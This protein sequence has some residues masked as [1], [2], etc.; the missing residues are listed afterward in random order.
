MPHSQHD[1]G[2]FLRFLAEHCPGL[3]FA[4]EM[5]WEA[6][7]FRGDELPTIHIADASTSVILYLNVHLP[8]FVHGHDALTVQQ[9]LHGWENQAHVQTLTDA[10]LT[11]AVL[12]GR[13][14]MV[15]GQINKFHGIIVPNENLEVPVY[16]EAEFTTKRYVLNSFIAH[17][18]DTSSSGHYYA[19]LRYDG[20][21]YRA[22][23]NSSA[24]LMNSVQ[25]KQSCRQSYLFFY[26]SS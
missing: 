5:T 25:F 7:S 13:F 12:A 16:T 11:L 18:G 10:P 9:L 23:D 2:D 1:V 21:Y 14:Q 20:A 8:N 6:R 24:K 26:Q 17:E 4:L 22:D 3:R 19:V 15:H